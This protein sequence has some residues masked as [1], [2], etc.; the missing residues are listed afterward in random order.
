MLAK[1]KLLNKFMSKLRL[2]IIQ[3]LNTAVNKIDG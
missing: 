3:F 1:V 2:R